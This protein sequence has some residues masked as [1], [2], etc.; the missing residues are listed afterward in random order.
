MSNFNLLPPPHLGLPSIRTASKNS[1]TA[2]PTISNSFLVV[3][4]RLQ[5]SECFKIFF[6]AFVMSAVNRNTLMDARFE[7][8]EFNLRESAVIIVIII[9]PVT[10]RGAMP[11]S[12]GIFFTYPP[13]IPE[14][15]TSVSWWILGRWVLLRRFLI[16]P[17]LHSDL[18]SVSVAA[19]VDPVPEKSQ[20]GSSEE[21]YEFLLIHKGRWAAVK[22]S[23]R[24]A[25]KSI[26]ARDLRNEWMSCS[27]WNL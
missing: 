17:Y 12:G 2:K 23:V 3:N 6:F 16:F 14:S 7:N 24:Y 15:F 9:I 25:T 13:W 26:L 19:P 20:D 4:F 5:H 27:I 10:K 21:R 1:T 8:Y 11:L 18:R 22:L